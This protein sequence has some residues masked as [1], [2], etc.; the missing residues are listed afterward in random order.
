M[1]ET[2]RGT[3][4]P[5]GPGN[6]CSSWDELRT[7]KMLRDSQSVADSTKKVSAAVGRKVQH[8]G[9]VPFETDLKA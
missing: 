3:N 5:L 7:Y 4:R 2:P 6:K 1:W 8:G 9:K